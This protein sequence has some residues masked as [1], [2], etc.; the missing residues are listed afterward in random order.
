MPRSPRIV[1][2]G[3]FYHVL[4]RANGR[5]RIFGKKLDFVA[6]EQVLAETLERHRMRILAYCIMPNHWHFVVWPHEDGD[7]PRFMQW[8]T[9]TH[10][11][12]WH[13]HHDTVGTGHLYQGRYKCFPIQGGQHLLRVLRYVERNPVRAG[14]V[15]RAEEWQW[16]SL[17]R[18]VR[19]IAEEPKLLH[20]WPIRLPED[21][22][23]KIN[24]QGEIGEDL[25]LIRE[26]ARR[27][28]P[29]GLPSWQAR[30]ADQLG[31]GSTLRPRGRP[32]KEP[33]EAEKGT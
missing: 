28:T 4:N 17:W 20:K 31:L 8:L 19:G 2:G 33:V 14:L 5:S 23:D 30:I 24:R 16:S 21:W 1:P 12:R 15:T 6:F 13:A 22:L 18:R 26:C 11:Q 9:L 25:R 27:G 29:L 32:R 7:L 3:F 10:T